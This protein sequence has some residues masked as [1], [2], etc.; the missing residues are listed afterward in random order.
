MT[1]IE[2]TPDGYRRIEEKIQSIQEGINKGLFNPDAMRGC[3]QA[4]GGGL[5]ELRRILREVCLLA[6]DAAGSSGPDAA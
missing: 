3:L 1:K 2:L 5:C 4:A 6:P